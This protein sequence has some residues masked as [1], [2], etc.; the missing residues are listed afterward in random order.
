MQD[1]LNT[2]AI[3][4]PAHGNGK[5]VLKAFILHF[6]F[7][8]FHF[9]FFVFPLALLLLSFAGCGSEHST[10]VGQTSAGAGAADRWHEELFHYAIENLNRLEEFA[11]QEMLPQVVDRLNQWAPYQEPLDDWQPDPLLATLPPPL[12]KLGVMQNLDQLRYTL[13]DAEALQQAFWIRDVAAWAGGSQPDDLTRARRLFDW[14]VRNVQ[15]EPPL[16][17][18]GKPQGHLPQLPWETLLTGRGAPI[19]R[20]WLFLLLARQ[21]GLDA[22]LL[23]VPDTAHHGVVIPWTIGVRIGQEVYLFDPT[24]GL[25][26]PAPDGIKLASGGPLEIQPATLSQL[27]AQ[28]A[29]LHKLDAGEK[30]PYPVQ[31]SQLAQV[32]V[33]VEAAPTALSKRMKLVQLR[34]AGQ[35]KA[36]VAVAPSQQLARWKN[37]PHV[38]GVRLWSFPFDTWQS[39]EHLTETMMRLKTVPLLPF[40][41]RMP[42]HAGRVDGEEKS[43]LVNALWKG[44]LL[45]LRGLFGGE[46][47]ATFFYQATRPPNEELREAVPQMAEQFFHSAL[48]ADPQRS[49]EQLKAA[50]K[51][52]AE[53]QIVLLVVAKH[54]ASYWLGLIL[55]EKGNYAGAIDYFGRRT[56]AALPN[57]PWLYGASYNLA[58][59]YEA[60]GD[61]RKAIELYRANAKQFGDTGQLLRATWLA[62]SSGVHL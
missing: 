46:S 36:V 17:I 42:I 1:T 6:S 28:D 12:A 32:V 40:Q 26:I 10:P 62:E 30:H 21:A 54:D 37:L 16:V 22:A 56:L 51:Q 59:S 44:R 15:R 13:F 19:D 29:L 50:A 48:A 55:F 31:K 7:C 2:V 41:T 52:Q 34:L 25:P 5:L 33:L 14:T 4:W 35:Q 27:V 61:Y 49:T 9:A 3:R 20:A 39:L 23:A 58:R 57:S 60:S 38:H 45:H 18:D 43:V 53:Q 47:S 8:I 11:P 24:L